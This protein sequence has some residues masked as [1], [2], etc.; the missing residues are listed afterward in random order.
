MMKRIALATLL[1][2]SPCLPALAQSAEPAPPPAVIVEDTAAVAGG[3][4]WP[5]LAIVVLAAVLASGD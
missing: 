4:V 1:A 3:I 5:M 2:V